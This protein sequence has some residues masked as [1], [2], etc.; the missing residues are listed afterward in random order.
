MDKKSGRKQTDATKLKLSMIASQ[1]VGVL[2]P[3]YIDGRT[4]DPIFIKES[5]R[6][7]KQENKDKV[8]I[9]NN[10]W[11]E[12]HPEDYKETKRKE[13]QRNKERIN[14]ANRNYAL[15]KR[16]AVGSFTIGDWELLKKQ[17]G[18]TCPLCLKSEPEITLTKDH[19][20]PISKGGSNFIENIQPLCGSCNS[21]KRDKINVF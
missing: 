12:N 14:L 21:R 8:R 9:I 4:S 17:Y 1:R 19:I 15:R 10:R 2:S 20:I 5:A 18:F 6:K 13:R 3:R 11:K 7:W 16:G